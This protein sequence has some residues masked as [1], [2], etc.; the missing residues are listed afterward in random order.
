GALRQIVDLAQAGGLGGEHLDE[1]VADDAALQ[2]GIGDVGQARQEPLGGVYVNDVH[3]QVATEGVQA[4]LRLVPAQEPVVHEDGGELVGRGAV[5]EGGGY[6]GVAT[7]GQREDH[8]SVAGPLLDV[9]DRLRDIR[10]GGPA[11]LTAADPV[12]E[13]C[14]EL[15]AVRGVR[16]LGMKL[17]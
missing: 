7:A 4:S 12:Q 5:N 14:Q 15:L 1:L 8:A 17:E 2:L 10:A 13:V 9:G 16:H 11:R 3:V 6:R